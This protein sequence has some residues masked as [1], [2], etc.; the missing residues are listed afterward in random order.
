MAHCVPEECF[1]LR[2]GTWGHQ[3]WLKR[4]ME[5]FGGDLSRMIQA[6]GFRYRIQSKFLDQLALENSGFDD[7]F[8]GRLIDDVAV[9]GM[10]TYFDS[11]SAVGVI[12]HAKNSKTL[13]GNLRNKRAAF[14]KRHQKMGATIK[15]IKVDGNSIEFLSTP[16]NRYRSF[17]V[18]AK[19]CHLFTTSLTLSLIHISEPTR[20]Y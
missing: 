11:G 14:A 3:L 15:E 17:Y 12:L 1:Y 13:D 16:D 19:D 6:R 10:D 2:F 5:E 9:I 8:G 18:V 4:L 7:L 20:P